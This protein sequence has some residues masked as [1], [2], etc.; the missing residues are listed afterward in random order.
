MRSEDLYR[1]SAKTTARVA[2]TDAV[3]ETTAKADPATRQGEAVTARDV[4]S[5]RP[6]E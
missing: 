1:Q 6:S 3:L 5:D 2:H 4:P